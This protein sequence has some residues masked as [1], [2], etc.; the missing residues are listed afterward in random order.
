MQFLP[1]SQSATI[2][3]GPFVDDT[4]FVTAET[5]LTI[6]NTDIR[7]SKNGGAFGAKNSG[8]GTHDENGWYSITLDTTDLSTSGPFKLYVNVSGA[9]PVWH[10]YHVLPTNYYNQLYGSSATLP[11]VNA[12]QIFNSQTA[13]SALSGI[14]AAV[15]S[16][17]VQSSPTTTSCGTNLTETDDDFYVGR[18][19]YFYDG[20]ASL[21]TGYDGTTK[22]LT[23]EE[24]TGA[25][26]ALQTAYIG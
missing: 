26:P 19:V 9:A 1:K 15:P 20:S 21:I 18:M 24:M 17:V 2:R 23:Y 10:E 4:D 8:G 3:I 7:I 14:M 25:P 6:A 5:G 13:A 11:Q 22:A 16:F 12:Y